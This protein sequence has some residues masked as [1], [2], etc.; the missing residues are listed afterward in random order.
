MLYAAWTVNI[1][2][3]EPVEYAVPS[4]VGRHVGIHIQEFTD[5]VYPDS[6]LPRLKQKGK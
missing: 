1:R 3:I 2:R 6:G 5:D 4:A